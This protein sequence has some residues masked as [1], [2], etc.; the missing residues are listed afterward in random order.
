[1]MTIALV[2]CHVEAQ[3]DEGFRATAINSSPI[4]RQSAGQQTRDPFFFNETMSLVVKGEPKP[5]HVL[6][7]RSIAGII[8]SQAQPDKAGRLEGQVFRHGLLDYAALKKRNNRFT[9]NLHGIRTETVRETT[10]NRHG[11]LMN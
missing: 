8:S 1:M 9:E 2:P 7:E 5:F 4:P 11:A 10:P 6:C 3:L